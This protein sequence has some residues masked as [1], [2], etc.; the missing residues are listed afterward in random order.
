MI[1]G[2]TLR[3][4]LPWHVIG[5]SQA[6]FA[7]DGLWTLHNADFLRDP[8]FARAYAAGRATGSWGGADIEWRVHVALWA[9]AQ[10]LAVRGDFIEFGVNRGGMSRA[11]VEYVD[12]AALGRS[13]FLLDTFAGFDPAYPA[14][15]DKNWQY[16]DTQALVA[17]TFSA[18]PRIEIVKGTVPA[19]LERVG[20]ERIAFAHIDM[21]CVEPEREALEWLWPRLQ[22]GGIILL[23]DYGWAGHEPQKEA[24]DRF[25]AE[26]RHMILSLPTGQGLLVRHA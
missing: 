24:H 3:R 9:A 22:T 7:R 25:A 2:P 18:F 11:I 15:Y 8:A 23:D 19:S 16:G 5:K 13:F 12:W 1:F 4:I 10:A 14:S 6:T 26:R 20:S 21:N 17:A